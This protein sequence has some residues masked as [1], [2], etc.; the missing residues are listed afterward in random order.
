MISNKSLIKNLINVNNIVVND[1]YFYMSSGNVKHIRINIRPK[2]HEQNRCPYCHKKCPGYDK[3]NHLKIWRHLDF[4]GII[5]EIEG[6]ANRIE[7]KEHGVV[8]ANVP[9][10]YPD[11]KFT[12][13]F[14]M[15]VAWLAK[16]LPKSA[17][18]EYM[19]IDWGTVGRCISRTLDVIEP[20]IKNRLNNLKIIGIDE[21]SYKKGYKYITVIVN[22][23]TNTVVWAHEGHGKE[24]LKLFYEELTEEQRNSIQVVTGDGAR[25]ITD[26]V[27]E[28][29]PNCER[30]VDPFHVVEW[31]G[32]AL[33]KVRTEAWQQAKITVNELNKNVRKGSGRY[34]KE[35]KDF[36]KLQEAKKIAKDI[37]NSS[38]AL[39]KAPEHLTEN[40]AIKL[41][42]I[43][44]SN[45]RLY[46]AYTLKEELR[47]LLKMKDVE[48]AEIELKKWRWKASHSRIDV[49]VELSKKIKR[50]EKH[51]LNTI[52]LGLSN[53]RIEANNNKIKLI[54][55]KA[56]GFRNLQNMLD[57]IYMV[58]SN[59]VIPLPNR[60]T[61][62]FKLV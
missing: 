50:H 53:A 26:C 52:K 10:A 44:N 56:Y 4:G 37:K 46:R 42:M 43:A 11:S 59:L 28:Y 55:R 48:T 17:V 60:K 39:E 61:K 18:A 45:P 6:Y 29:T 13:D 32:D 47:L 19:R 30:C 58:C 35:D 25:W 31:C 54:I 7:C 9:W 51:I 20:N 1:A 15:T 5:V 16:Y 62:E 8:T 2:K 34:K 38:F 14:D 41:E 23:E 21:T 40:Q 57:M 36:E 22:H 24:I 3:T 49:F 27:N 12:K 33:N